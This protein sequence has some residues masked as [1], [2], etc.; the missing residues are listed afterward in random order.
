MSGGWWHNSEAC[1]SGFGVTT[2]FNINPW[3]LLPVIIVTMEE[4]KTETDV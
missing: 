1:G 3:H 2:V 4:M